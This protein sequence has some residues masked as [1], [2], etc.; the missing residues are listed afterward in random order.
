M[1]FAGR[2]VLIDASLISSS[3]LIVYYITLF[4]LNTVAEPACSDWVQMNL[5]DF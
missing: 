5:M 4:R 1:S 3:V 2:K